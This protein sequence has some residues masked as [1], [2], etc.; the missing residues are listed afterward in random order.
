MKVKNADNVAN[1]DSALNVRGS[2]QIQEMTAATAEK[3]IVQAL[4]FVI[5]LRYFAPTKQWNP[6]MNVLFPTNMTAVNHQAHFEFQKRICP[7]S[8]TSLTSG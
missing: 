6:W 3:P 2:E 4:W 7:I 1:L 5:V 8:H